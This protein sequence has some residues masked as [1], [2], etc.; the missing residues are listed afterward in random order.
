MYYF[1]NFIILETKSGAIFIF[2][3]RLNS[4][5]AEFDTLLLQKNPAHVEYKYCTVKGKIQKFDSN[6]DE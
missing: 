6:D 5:D 1:R 4:A 2:I 3:F